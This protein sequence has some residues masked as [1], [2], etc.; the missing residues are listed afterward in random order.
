MLLPHSKLVNFMDE[1]GK[2]SMNKSFLCGP[3]SWTEKHKLV[4]MLVEGTWSW[5]AGAVHWERE[6]L[7]MMNSTQLRV[8]RLA[9]GIRRGAAEVWVAYNSRSLRQVRAW[10]AQAGVERWSCKILR[11]QFQL[12]GHWMRQR[13]GED[14]VRG[15]AGRRALGWWN[16]EKSLTTGVRH[17]MRFRA[18]NLE[19]SLATCLGENWYLACESRDAW[20]QLLVKWL[21]DMDVPW[22]RGRQLCLCA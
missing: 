21:A 14:Q 5:S 7:E 11:L 10:I 8:L 13:E 12:A 6:E 22:T 16:R 9:F 4:Q 18:S 2:H 15:I 19:R 20:K 17:P 1:C 3:G